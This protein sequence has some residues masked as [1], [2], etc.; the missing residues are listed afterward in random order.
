[1]TDQHDHAEEI[2]YEDLLGRMT[3]LTE[4][5]EQTDESVSAPAFELLDCL[6][7]WHRTGLEHLVAALPA[8]ALEHAREDPIVAHLLDTYLEDEELADPTAL[9]EQALEEIRP[10]V[11]SHGG[12]MELVGVEGGVVTLRMLGACEG[13]PSSTITLTKGVEETLR[14]R[15]RGFERLEVEGDPT[16][17]H[18]SSPSQ[19]LLQIQSLRSRGGS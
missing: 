19:P 8:D 13:C 10:Y 11:H 7:A 17:T 4:E 12:E 18:E 15:W 5:L 1:M 9:V 6:E 3:E 16:H 2:D 14:A